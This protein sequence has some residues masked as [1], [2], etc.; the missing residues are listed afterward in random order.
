[1]SHSCECNLNTSKYSELALNKERFSAFNWIQDSNQSTKHSSDHKVSSNTVLPPFHRFLSPLQKEQHYVTKYLNPGWSGKS[2]CSKN[3]FKALSFLQTLQGDLFYT[4][5]NEVFPPKHLKL[6]YNEYK[7]YFIPKEGTCLSIDQFSFQLKNLGQ[8]NA[9]LNDFANYYSAR[10]VMQ[11]FLQLRL[12][13]TIY[14]KLQ[15]SENMKELLSPPL[16]LNKIFAKGTSKELKAKCL[17]TNQYSWYRPAEVRLPQVTMLFNLSNLL[18]FPETLKLLHALQ[19]QQS[20]EQYSHALSHLGIGLLVNCLQV[21]LPKW[22]KNQVTTSQV[23]HQSISIESS[24]YVGDFLEELSVSHWIA[25]ENNSHF[26]WDEILCPH[27]A[28]YNLELSPFEFFYNELQQLQLLCEIQPHYNVPLLEFI[29]HVFHRWQK[30]V[31]SQQQTEFFLENTPV[32]ANTHFDRVILSYLQGN[33]NNTHHGLIQKIQNALSHIKEDGYL[34]VLTNQNLYLPSQSHKILNLFKSLT[35]ICTIDLSQIKGK[36]ESPDFIYVLRKKIGIEVN[37]NS[38]AINSTFRFSGNLHSFQ[39]FC[40]IPEELNKFF[41]RFIKQTPTIFQNNSHDHE[42][43]IQFD[44]YQS[45][46]INGVQVYS[47]D[48][49]SHQVTHPQF[50]KKLLYNTMPLNYFFHIT[51]LDSRELM[52]S[53]PSWSFEQKLPL[54]R[55]GEVGIQ[56]DNNLILILDLKEVHLPKISLTTPQRIKEKIQEFGLSECYYYRLV[57]KFKSVNLTLFNLFIDSKIG[58][59]IAGISLVGNKN[60]VR[61]KINSLLVP[62]FII[63]N[64]FR[65]NS[66]NLNNL[67]EVKNYLEAIQFNNLSLNELAQNLQTLSEYQ[68]LLSDVISKSKVELAHWKEIDFN[69]PS[70][71][72]SLFQMKLVPIYPHN[73][74]LNIEFHCQHNHLNQLSIEKHEMSFDPVLSKIHLISNNT[75]QVT[76]SGNSALIIFIHFLL[77]QLP[78]MTILNLLT[79]VKVPTSKDCTQL[80]QIKKNEVEYYEQHFIQVNSAIEKLIHMGINH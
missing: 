47:N 16:A 66:L 42:A 8:E 1:L 33:K 48:N 76:F 23:S 71:R 63:E 40:H 77:K 30:N 13:K 41:Q 5:K 56:D 12:L 31:Y 52:D 64:S 50:L 68:S 32:N 54:A 60:Q 53:K 3:Y 49:D 78:K 80:L 74:E 72:N 58:K 24:L 28:Q 37:N 11:Y 15:I 70:I 59:Q 39:S 65:T 6:I 22:Y 46:I 61:S 25:Q 18:S 69:T 73:Q 57:P 34:L 9:L 14:Q 2:L 55:E 4:L 17:E 10:L 79:N 51:L 20:H 38:S 43:G 7:N 27:F 26:K 44:F 75:T 67:P 36:G 45:P 35:P 19:K 29:T 62:A 21:N